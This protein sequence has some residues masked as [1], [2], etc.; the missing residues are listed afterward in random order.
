MSDQIMS[1]GKQGAGPVWEI[2][3]ES[4]SEGNL[5][6][7]LLEDGDPATIPAAIGLLSLGIAFANAEDLQNDTA[8]SVLFKKSNADVLALVEALFLICQSENALNQDTANDVEITLAIKKIS[9]EALA[10]Y[11]LGA[12]RYIHGLYGRYYD[13]V[14]LDIFVEQ[15]CSTYS[16]EKML[17]SAALA[18]RQLE[19]IGSRNFT[20]SEPVP[21]NTRNQML[22]GV[23]AMKTFQKSVPEFHQSLDNLFSHF[24]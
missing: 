8:L 22:L 6:D 19:C 10:E 17:A 20:K 11:L 7:S 24:A 13:Q 18:S 14:N 3:R 21:I 9:K 15:T 12:R 2:V 5:Y 23:R 4:L 1:G 16:R